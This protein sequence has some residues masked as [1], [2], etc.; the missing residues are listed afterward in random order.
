MAKSRYASA[1]G[2]G[3][4]LD[5]IRASDLPFAF[6]SAEG[7]W[8]TK[9]SCSSGAEL[10]DCHIIVLAS[11]SA[12]KGS[13]RLGAVSATMEDA[14]DAASILRLTNHIQTLHPMPMM[15]RV[16]QVFAKAE[17]S[18]NGVIR[19]NRHTMLTDSD[20]HSTRHARAAVGGLIAGLV[21]DC[22]I[23]VSGG[24]E[25]QGPAG[26][27]T[28]CIVYSVEIDRCGDLPNL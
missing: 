16:V 9:A 14:I 24:A 21:G 23:Y 20:I 2:V 7:Y 1:L 4:A 17:A 5:E 22:M 25:G 26:G 27:G 15:P 6:D 11:D 13:V 3:L 12:Y 8:S 18:P 28:L 19:G 10:E